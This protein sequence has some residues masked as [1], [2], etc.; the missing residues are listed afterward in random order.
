MSLRKKTIFLIL[1]TNFIL[2]VVLYAVLAQNWFQTIFSF[3]Q[4]AIQRDLA[5]VAGTLKHELDSLSA[6]AAD[7]SI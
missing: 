3:E 5:R 1:T 7:W 4:S 6:A 2:V